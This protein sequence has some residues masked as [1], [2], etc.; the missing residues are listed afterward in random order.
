[1]RYRRLGNDGDFLF[2]GGSNLY[3]QG[4]AAVQQAIKTRIMHWTNEWWEDLNAGT[5]MNQ[6][7]GGRDMDFAD[8]ALQE[9]VINTP[10][11][12]SILFWESLFNSDNRELKFHIVVDTDFG[13]VELE[14][15]TAGGI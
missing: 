13:Q 5:P 10:H 15:V 2:G 14:E 6:I 3:L 12:T 8:K 11:V 9:R 1:M 7:L 4:A